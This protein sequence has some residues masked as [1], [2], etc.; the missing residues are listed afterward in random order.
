VKNSRAILSPPVVRP[1]VESLPPTDGQHILIYTTDSTWKDRLAV[2]L[3]SFHGQ[4]F[5]VYGFDEA[6]QVGNCEFKRTSTEQ[7]LQ[8]LASCRGI[9]TTAGFSLLSECLHLRKK[10]LLLPV[11]GQYEQ[12]I[13]G[14]YAERLGLALNRTSLNA[15]TLM[16]YLDILDAPIADHSDILWPDNRAFF[17]I[18]DQ[19]LNMVFSRYRTAPGTIPA[20]RGLLPG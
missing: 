11:R 15:K 14:Q 1:V 18:L 10:M 5:R 9:I 4:R 8:D 7:F 17:N 6:R 2:L 3:N 19:T 13:N 20:S 16:E 12:V